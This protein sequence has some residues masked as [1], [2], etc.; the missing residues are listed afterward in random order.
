MLAKICGIACRKHGIAVK[1]LA[2]GYNKALW[3]AELSY[4]SR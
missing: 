4:L 1:I 2:M 3:R